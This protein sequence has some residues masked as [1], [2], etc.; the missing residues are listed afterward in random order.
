M[1]GMLYLI[2]ACPDIG[3]ILYAKNAK[4]LH[5]VQNYASEIESFLKDRKSIIP[6]FINDK[7]I[8]KKL[9]PFN[10][11]KQLH[12]ASAQQ[13]PPLKCMNGGKIRYKE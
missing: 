2:N 11:F 6:K 12:N 10:T 1:K 7:S 4:T 8:L 5:K 3:N 9:I 13:K